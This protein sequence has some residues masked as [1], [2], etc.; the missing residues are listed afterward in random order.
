MVSSIRNERLSS[1]DTA[2]V[3]PHRTEKQRAKDEEKA[4]KHAEKEAAKRE[5]EEHEKALAMEE[6]RYAKV[7]EETLAE[8]RRL[9]EA[10]AL[11]KSDDVNAEFAKQIKLREHAEI[12]QDRIN[13][14]LFEADRSL[15]IFRRH[16]KVL[17]D[18]TGAKSNGDVVSAVRMAFNKAS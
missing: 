17:R 2:T 12:G 13:N 9:T 16:F 15:R 11:L 6:D 14:Q 1:D 7:L 5:R 18:I 4:R 8:N 3:S 10:L